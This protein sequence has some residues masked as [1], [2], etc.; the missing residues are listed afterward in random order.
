MFVKK[1]LE[2]E[3]FSKNM[4]F[5]KWSIFTPKYLSAST[6]SICIVCKISQVYRPR[7]AIS[8]CVSLLL[9][10]WMLYIIDIIEYGCKKHMAKKKQILN[11]TNPTSKLLNHPKKP[12]ESTKIFTSKINF[13][14][15]TQL[16]NLKTLKIP[17]KM[18]STIPLEAGL[19]VFSTLKI[20]KK[21][22]LCRLFAKRTPR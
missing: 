3:G 16:S 21:R 22:R 2:F 14:D 7:F 12:P 10:L 9:E 6:D 4:F 8:R 5:L 15:Q 19:A 1:L 11:T 13:L 18:T 17:K 20:V